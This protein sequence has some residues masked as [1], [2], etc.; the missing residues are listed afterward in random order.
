MNLLFSNDQPGQYPSSWYVNS[1]GDIPV[2]PT[3]TQDLTCDVCVV[4]GGYT[5]LSTAL[6]LAQQGVNVILVEAHRMGWGAS[7][8]NGGQLGTGF[9]KDQQWL[10]AKLGEHRAKALWDISE[11]AKALIKQLIN[12]W[13]IDCHLTPGVTSA[14]WRQRDLKNEIRYAEYLA[15]EYRYEQLKPLDALG[16]A[17]LTGSEVYCGGVLDEGAYH[18]HPLK[19]AIGLARAAAASGTQ[20]FENTWVTD[21]RQSS[22]NSV[23]QAT[24][25]VTDHG[26]IQADSV[27]L[28]CNGYQGKLASKVSKHSRDRVM[29]INNF[30]VATE[31]LDDITDNILPSDVAV[32]DSRFVVNYYRR[33]HDNRLLFGGGENYGYRFP[34][35]IASVVRKPM[36]EAFPQLADCRI[37]YAW[38]GTLAITMNRM[39]CFYRHSRQLICVSGYSGHGVALAV[40]SGKII[41]EA[42]LGRHERFDL[43]QSIPAHPFPGGSHLRSPLLALAMTWY[44]LRD[45]LG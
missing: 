2:Y 41:S 13:T 8:R 4:G 37:D 11:A 45:K 24:H 40:M 1:A 44:A 3:L 9:N 20:L 32:A 21:I 19:L 36:T 34:A 31:P 22:D 15:T 25:V 12:D 14:Q 18:L 10:T 16:M 43:L 23:R 39:P 5:G 30:I 6:H 27:V 17:E 7:G 33:S 42:L 35:D 26:V 28:A 29:P 38:G